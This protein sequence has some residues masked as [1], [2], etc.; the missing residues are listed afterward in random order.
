MSS[1]LSPPPPSG[2]PVAVELAGLCRRF[3]QRW[4]FA[5][6]DLTVRAGERVLIFGPNGCG[7]T[8]LLRTVATAIA[9]SAGR[10]RLFGMDPVAE[11]DAV[12]AR[13][14]ILS[15]PL[16][17][18][19]DLS[20]VDN[21]RALARLC[22]SDA[23]PEALLAQV[24]LEES[25]PDPVRTWSAGMRKRLQF[26]ALVLQRPS[27]VLLDEPFAALDPGGMAQ[28]AELIRGLDCT[29]LMASHQLERAG[30]LCDRALLLDRG[31]QRW[32]GPAAHAAEAWR[33]LSGEGEP[34]ARVSA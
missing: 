20:G 30:A 16:G 21:L 3:G 29:L 11:R 10:M 15:H 6:L 26:A 18:Y 4:A 24:G 12:R 32:T 14:A 7:K 25:R 28:V 34:R 17:M 22:G 2:A 9:P 23:R 33:A 13:L 27:L 5:R 31:L 1:P 19:E 8:T